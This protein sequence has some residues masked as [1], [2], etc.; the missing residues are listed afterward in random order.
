VERTRRQQGLSPTLTDSV[1][2]IRLVE[3]L[4]PILRAAALAR[5]EVEV[6][7]QR[8]PKTRHVSSR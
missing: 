2:I 4:V 6:Q 8:M 1:G 3:L 7:T 5:R